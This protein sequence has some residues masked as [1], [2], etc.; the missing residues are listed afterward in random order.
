[1]TGDS[2]D[3]LEEKA[4]L[5]GIK[6]ASLN[7]WQNLAVELDA[8]VIINHLNGINF[9]WRIKTILLNAKVLAKSL[10]SASWVNIPRNTN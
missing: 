6:L 9:S 5:E 3:E 10:D 7:K 4:I 8:T 2:L 1:M